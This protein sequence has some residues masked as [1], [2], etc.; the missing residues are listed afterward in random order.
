MILLSIRKS[1]I[2]YTNSEQNNNTSMEEP[3]NNSIRN[4]HSDLLLTYSAN[5]VFVIVHYSGI[6]GYY[7]WMAY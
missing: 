2:M 5:R 4:T 3:K 1:F 7:S 6:R